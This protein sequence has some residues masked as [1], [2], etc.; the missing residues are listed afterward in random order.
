MWPINLVGQYNM[1]P[2]KKKI[3]AMKDKALCDLEYSDAI[4]RLAERQKK[5]T[6]QVYAQKQTLNL[7]TEFGTGQVKIA[8]KNR[9]Q[10]NILEGIFS[11]DPTVQ[12]KWHNHLLKVFPIGYKNGIR[13]LL[14]MP[15]EVDKPKATAETV[16]EPIEE[17]ADPN[18]PAM[19]RMASFKKAQAEAEAVAAAKTGT[20]I[21]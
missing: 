12:L 10:Q 18:S 5:L 17:V 21:T 20:N 3:K 7:L 8:V 13:K 1:A 11:A 6:A 16:E 4:A 15:K 19:L 2:K 14:E 9:A